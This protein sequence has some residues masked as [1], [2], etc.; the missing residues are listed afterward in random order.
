ME[1]SFFAVEVTADD[2][3]AVIARWTGIPVQS[4]KQD[5][6]KKLARN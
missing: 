6:T 3:E 4:V 5:E 1:D 2:V